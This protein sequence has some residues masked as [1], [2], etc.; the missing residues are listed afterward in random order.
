MGAARWLSFIARLDL[1]SR[2]NYCKIDSGS[3]E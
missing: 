1:R 3:S 2:T